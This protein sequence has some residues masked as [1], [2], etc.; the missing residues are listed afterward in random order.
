MTAT[1]RTVAAKLTLPEMIIA[2]F[3]TYDPLSNNES[4]TLTERMVTLST[5]LTYL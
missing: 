2:R 3:A 5:N 1:E 4:K